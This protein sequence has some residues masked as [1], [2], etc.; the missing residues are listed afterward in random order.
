MKIIIAGCGRLGSGLAL[1][2]SRQG[3]NVTV[4][5]SNAKR[6]KSLAKDFSGKTIEGVEYDKDTLVKAGIQRTDSLISC[7]R[8]D[9][10]NALVARIARNHYRVPKVIAQ[11]NDSR[12]KE[13]F[14]SL[15]IQVI[16]TVQWGIARTKELLTFNRVERVMSIGNTP[17]EIIRVVIPALLSGHTI[18]EA[19]PVNEAGLVAV[20]RGNH[21]FIPAPDT[22]LQNQDIVY[23]S[24]LAD[25]MDEISRILDL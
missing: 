2:L 12:K 8:S 10:V 7:T 20:N 1:E 22:K 6:F 19:F 18:R 24:V 15:G 13:I 23:L 4:I 17:V 14:N 11:L 21:S 9:E 3:E 25:S 5:S 16:T